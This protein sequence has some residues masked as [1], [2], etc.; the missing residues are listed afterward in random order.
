MLFNWFDAKEAER[1]GVELG[2]FYLEQSISTAAKKDNTKAI[3]KRKRTLDQIAQR[4]SEFKS[5]EKLN[6]YKKGKLS[7]AFGGILSDAALDSVQMD[8]IMRWLLMRL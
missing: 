6:I 3:N 5:R 8:E 2:K 1:F 7:K 4:L